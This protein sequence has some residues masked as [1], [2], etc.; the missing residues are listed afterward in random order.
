MI[1]DYLYILII[2][3]IVRWEENMILLKDSVS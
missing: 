1:I 2:D 3:N